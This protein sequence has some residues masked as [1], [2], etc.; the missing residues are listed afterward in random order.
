MK[1]PEWIH[2]PVDSVKARVPSREDIK[3]KFLATRKGRLTLVGSVYVGL[4]LIY[5]AGV[6]PYPAGAEDSLM[7]VK[8]H[9]MSG[10]QRGAVAWFLVGGI[11]MYFVAE[12]AIKMLY[13]PD[14][15]KLRVIDPAGKIEETW[16]L[17]DEML[18]DLEV[19]GGELATRDTKDGKIW[20]CKSYNP[21]ENVAE[22]TWEGSVDARKAYTEKQNL[23]DCIE[24]TQDRAREAD[25]YERN[26]P[27]FIRQGVRAELVEWI[28]DM[29]E[30]DPIVSGR[31]YRKAREEVLGE[32]I[33]EDSSEREEEIRRS[34]D[35][36]ERKNGKSEE[37]VSMDKAMPG[38]SE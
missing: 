31:G 12:K 2:H 36:R 32:D 28:D 23:N 22:V 8:F 30:I 17:G 18:A 14:K 15:N 19:E 7:Q 29:D 27:E 34:D 35:E 5:N 24:D 26:L 6:V 33:S 38:G 20:L 3:Q 11:P 10:T 16:L 21:E 37:V 1:L 25:K 13:Q 9:G 4:A